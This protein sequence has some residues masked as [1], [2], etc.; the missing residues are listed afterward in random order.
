VAVIG[1]LV[2][3]LFMTLAFLPCAY[4]ILPGRPSKTASAISESS[5]QA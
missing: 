2:F 4:L 3:S 1:G 5:E